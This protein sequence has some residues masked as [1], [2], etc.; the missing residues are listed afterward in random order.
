[1]FRS[2]SL[3]ISFMFFTCLAYADD[4]PKVYGLL[5]GYVSDASLDNDGPAPD[6]DGIAR[7]LAAEIGKGWL[8]GYLQYEDAKVDLEL[9]P[10]L[11]ERVDAEEL[12][13]GI[14]ARKHFSKGTGFVSIERF[15]MK[16]TFDTLPADSSDFGI[17]IHTGGDYLLT[18][19]GGKVPLIGSLDLGYFD[20]QKSKA[21]EI[22]AGFKTQLSKNIGALLIY[23]HF[24]Q[25]KDDS[26]PDT[27]LTG[28]MLG[29]AWIF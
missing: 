29:L 24:E 26:S 16:Q 10:G 17:G 22:R 4:K 19:I 11:E 3:L 9:A 13:L 15:S 21:K 14:G 2:L 7:G 25:S 28:P 8:Y 18:M 27:T 5:G 6:G 20:L 12:R 23:R 1:M